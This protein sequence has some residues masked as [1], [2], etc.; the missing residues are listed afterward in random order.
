M[1]YTKTINKDLL[2]LFRNPKTFLFHNNLPIRTAQLA[3]FLLVLCEFS[4]IGT[5]KIEKRN[6]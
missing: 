2:T 1:F 6:A 4:I 3:V 5:A